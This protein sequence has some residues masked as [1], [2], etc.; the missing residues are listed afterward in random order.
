MGVVA[1][2]RALA[3]AAIEPA[4]HLPER[5]GAVFGSDYMLTETEEFT[6][7]MKKCLDENGEFHF[8]K[9][10]TA[11]L[12]EMTPLWMLKYLPNMPGSHIAIFNDLRGPSNS[13]TMRESS[14]NLA[15][16]EAFNCIVRGSADRMVAGATG[17][18]LHPMK[19]VHA[20][21]TEQLAPG[22]DDLTQAARPF[23]ADRQ[24]M[25]LGEGAACLILEELSVA[26][27]RGARIYGEVVGAASS[28]VA[29][30]NLVANRAAALVNAMRQTLKTAG[31]KP[32][33]IG[34]INAHGLGSH[35][36]DIEEAKAIHEV[37]GDIATQVPVVAAKSYFGNLGAASG[38]V[39]L[40]CSLLA[41][42][43]GQLFPVLNYRTPD[44]ACQLN[45]VTDH[46]TPPGSCF[47]KLS[48]TPQGQAAVVAVK[49]YQA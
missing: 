20:A 43:H 48:F 35:S 26:E 34:H 27:A 5:H 18:R 41:F 22:G 32:S 24:G 42:Q 45:I 46:A 3:D 36:A 13:I 4:E 1:A 40:I 7:G 6:A 2:H 9:W 8:E 37:F 17:T 14:S 12:G 15:I 30:K 38:A 44:P 23:D 21:Q 19:A 39:E 11:G 16:D 49:A 33:D 25:V 29:E 47:L 31:L 28:I 10:G